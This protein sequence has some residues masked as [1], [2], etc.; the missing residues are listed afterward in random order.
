MKLSG[1]RHQNIF[2][3]QFLIIF[4]KKLALRTFLIFPQKRFSDILETELSYILLKKVFLMFQEIKVSI[5][6]NE[7]FQ[8]G[9]FWPQKQKKS[10]LNFFFTFL[11]IKFSIPKLKK[12]LYFFKRT[13]SGISGWNVRSLKNRNS[14]YFLK[15]GFYV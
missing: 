5:P 12:L 8:K 11:E 4:P 1:L 15:K 2:S 9:T 13:F 14:L 7:A 10:A 6:K 3:K